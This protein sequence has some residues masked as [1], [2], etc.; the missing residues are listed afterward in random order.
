ME[1][2]SAKERARKAAGAAAA[3]SSAPR[4]ESKV[5]SLADV[6]A[7]W[8]FALVVKVANHKVPPEAA[9]W[10]CQKAERVAAA[11]D[12]L[13]GQPSLFH[14]SSSSSS[15]HSSSFHSSSSP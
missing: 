5:K 2:S 7:P 12:Y 15:F 4:F 14:S 10:I 3:L 8:L 1:A 6:P 11:M 13:S 9:T